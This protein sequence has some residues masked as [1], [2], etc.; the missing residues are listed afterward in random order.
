MMK[1]ELLPSNNSYCDD[2]N[3][4]LELLLDAFSSVV[5]LEDIASAYCLAGRDVYAA[6]ELL[7]HHKGSISGP[8]GSKG[9]PDGA[10]SSNLPT[11]NFLEKSCVERNSIP[12]KQRNRPISMGTVSGVIG[13]EYSKTKPSSYVTVAVEKPLK[14]NLPPSEVYVESSPD[15][16]ANNETM[17]ND[18]EEFLF[19]MLGDGFKLDMGVIREVLGLCGYDV[20]KSMEKLLDMSASRFNENDDDSCMLPPNKSLEAEGSQSNK[21]MKPVRGSARSTET[22]M[23]TGVETN[24]PKKDK[25]TLQKDIMNSLFNVAGRIEDPPRRIIRPVTGMRRGRH[26]RPVLEPPEDIIVEPRIRAKPKVVK[27][28]PHGSYDA[29]RLAHKEYFTT[30][31]EYY[32]AATDAYVKGDY[33]LSEKLMEQGN[34]FKK[35][36]QEADDKSTEKLLENSNENEEVFLDLHDYEPKEARRSLK[37]HLTSLS[38]IEAIPHLKVFVGSNENDAKREAR[39][40]VIIELLEKESI[41]W[42]EED[43]GQ[44]IAIRVDKID[45]KRLSFAK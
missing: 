15:Y 8:S 33:E 28:E 27:E 21:V 17:K 26:G 39:K 45:P 2:D 1:M 40:K 20:N 30:M 10:S 24:S 36:T 23:F 19:K 3:K 25:D 44:I 34:F 7:S 5:S 12:P 9:N 41:G 4:N 42:T 32:K 37:S 22:G 38:G 13:R 31:R 16:V 43:S 35:K 11:D 29:L 6:G 14:L 18:V